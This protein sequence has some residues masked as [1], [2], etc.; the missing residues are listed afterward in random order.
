MSQVYEHEGKEYAGVRKVGFARYKEVLED[1]WKGFVIVGFINL[2]FYIPFAAGMVYAILSKSALI[3][4]LSGIIGG[5]AAGPGI[6]CMY[7]NVLRRLRNDYSDWWVCWKKAL[8]QNWRAAVIPGIVQCVF[9]GMFV[10][11]GALMLWGATAPSLGTVALLLF[12]SLIMMMVL[13]VWWAQL[14]LFSQKTL[15]MIKNSL[16]F[17]LF[18][19]GRMLGS[20]ALQ[21]GFW[22]IM[23]L[24]LPWTAFILPVLSVWYI[25]FLSLLIIYRPLNED[26]KIEEQIRKAFPGTLP[27]EEYIP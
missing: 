27:A 18:H 26:F 16:F 1:H 25:R 21:V 12:G 20:S 13:T 15:I 7:D 10:F 17:S 3:A 23:F 6:A 2:L 22:L 11:S 5:A 24:F 8:S 19:L 4:L 14:V 9:I